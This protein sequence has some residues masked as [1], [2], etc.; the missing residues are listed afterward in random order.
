MNRLNDVGTHERQQFI[1]TFDVLAMVCE[2]AAP[3]IRLRQFVGLN[4]RPHRTVENHD[5]LGQCL[6]KSSASGVTLDRIGQ[7]W[8]GHY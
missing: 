5:A 3:K 6:R 8:I 7:A 2:T 4:H 1:V